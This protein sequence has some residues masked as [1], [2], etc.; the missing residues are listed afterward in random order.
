[1]RFLTQSNLA[2]N[3]RSLQRVLR[4]LLS[5]RAQTASFKALIKACGETE[6]ETVDSKV[7]FV[8]TARGHFL[9]A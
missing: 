9:R 8:Y 6:I 7:L 1:M 3:C 4:F 5:Q 2:A